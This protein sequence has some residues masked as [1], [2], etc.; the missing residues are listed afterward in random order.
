MYYIYKFTNKTNGKAYIGKTIDVERRKIE[1]LS[2][3]KTIANNHFYNAIKKYGFDNFDLEI[4]S[5]HESED[6]AYEAESQH[7]AQYKSNDKAL[8]YNSTTGGEGLKGITDETRKKMSDNGKLRVGDK[9]SFFG[10]HHS[11]Y[12]KKKISQANVGN[13]SWL[14]KHH[15]DESKNKMSEANAGK[16]FSPNTEFVTGQIPQNAK[17]TMEQA[18]ELRTKHKNGVSDEILRTEYGLTKLT[19]WRIITNRSYKE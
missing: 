12:S 16:R 15:T 18:Q 13:T 9:N 14:G 2:R 19:L 3:S 5:E 6:S 7:I 1:H 11:I 4:L 17:L 8:G 10:K